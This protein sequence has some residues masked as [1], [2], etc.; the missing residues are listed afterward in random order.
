MT[1][2]HIRPYLRVANVYEDRIDTTDI[3]EMNFTPDEFKIYELKYGDIFST[4]AKASS[5]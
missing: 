4:K 1:G 5:G 3:N 2:D